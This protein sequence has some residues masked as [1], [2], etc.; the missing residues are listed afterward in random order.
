MTKLISAWPVLSIGGIK[1]LRQTCKSG[2]LLGSDYVDGVKCLPSDTILT[3][4]GDFIRINLLKVSHI[5][6]FW[7]A[8][9]T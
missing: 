4:K 3:R 1:A 5:S 2:K 7:V 9:D 6:T 8:T